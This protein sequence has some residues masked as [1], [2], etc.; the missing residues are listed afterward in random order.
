M[1]KEN[2]KKTGIRTAKRFAN[3]VRLIN[4]LT[5]LNDGHKFERCFR[6]VYPQE[7]N[8]QK[9]SD[10]NTKNSF[11]DLGIKIRDNRFCASY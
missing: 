5:V 8:L 3:T 7:L 9:D 10:I 4:D 2:K 11:L 1:D 6:E